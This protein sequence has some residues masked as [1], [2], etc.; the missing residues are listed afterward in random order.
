M[1]SRS[2]NPPFLP[3]SSRPLR[4]F[5]FSTCSSFSSQKDLWD[6]SIP[7]ET[8][9]YAGIQKNESRHRHSSQAVFDFQ[10]HQAVD[11]V[12]HFHTAERAELAASQRHQRLINNEEASR[13]SQAQTQ[14]DEVATLAAP[15]GV[16]AWSIPLDQS[17]RQ[18]AIFIGPVVEAPSKAPGRE[19]GPAAGTYLRVSSAYV[20]MHRPLHKEDYLIAR[21]ANPRTGVVTPGSHSASS[22]VDGKS[23]VPHGRWRQRGD[24][25]ISSDF[26][27]ETPPLKQRKERLS[28]PHQ[29]LRL[30]PKLVA[31]ER[32]SSVGELS[33]PI[34]PLGQNSRSSNGDTF[35]FYRHVR[36]SEMHR[37]VPIRTISP[38]M[39]QKQS[40]GEPG[41]RRKPVGTPPKGKRDGA[42]SDSPAI[43][44]S[45]DTVL[46][47]PKLETD[48]RSSSAPVPAPL[49]NF[50]PCN[51][52]KDLP[53]LPGDTPRS[54]S[55]E[56]RTIA[57]QNPFL[58][59]EEKE[60]AREFPDPTS[61]GSTGRAIAQKDLPC[62]PM[63][64]GPSRLRQASTPMELGTVRDNLVSPKN[65]MSP[66]AES[67]RG[68]R[69]GNPAYPF[70]RLARQTHPPPQTRK[71]NGPLGVRPMPVP[72]YDNPPKQH[73]PTMTRP[74]LVR[75]EGP[76]SMPPTAMRMPNR[77]RDDH[78][79][80]SN[81]TST[82]TSTTISRPGLPRQ[83]M[84]GPRPSMPDPRMTNTGRPRVPK[85]PAPPD[86]PGI[87]MNT[88]MNM[89]SDSIMPML[90]PRVRPRG[91][92]RPTMPVR[93][94]NMHDV[95][96]MMPVHK[97]SNLTSM[98]P[99]PLWGET[100]WER[101]V[102]TRS[103]LD[104]ERSLVPPPLRPRVQSGQEHSTGTDIH[105]EGENT[106]VNSPGLTRK[107]SRCHNGFVDVKRPGLGGVIHTS[108]HQKN[109]ER[110]DEGSKLIHP[111]GSP[112][113]GLPEESDASGNEHQHGENQECHDVCCPDC[114]KEQD[115]H[116]SCLGHPS[117]SSMGSPGKTIWS[118]AHS[119]SSASE[120]EGWDYGKN[121]KGNRP[122]PE[123]HLTEENTSSPRRSKLRPTGRSPIELSAQPRT[124]T[125]PFKK[126]ASSRNELVSKQKSSTPG[127]HKRQRSCSSPVIGS[128]G[129]VRKPNSSQGVRLASGSRLRV[130]T[131]TGLAIS[132]IGLPRNRN[133]SGTSIGTIEVQLPGLGSFGGGAVSDL[134]LVPFEATKMWIKNHPQAMKIGWQALE[135]GWQMSQV[136]TTTAWRLWAL[137]FV[138][139]KTG[140]LK[141][142]VSK[143]ETA[144]GFVI[145]CARSALYL[146]VFAAVGVFL[147]RVLGIVLGLFGIVGWFVKTIFW[148]LGKVLGSGTVR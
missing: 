144:G 123:I 38:Q 129:P 46:R 26:E 126:A 83:L 98:G 47:H 14:T 5:S 87:F 78:D 120:S 50:G 113:P 19:S 110:V 33:A 8:V 11:S 90:L 73:S 96:K 16:D 13:I 63:N 70:T 20:D 66:P 68:P 34:K 106:K 115:V 51:V 80:L 130:P 121:Q 3:R 43:D 127:S 57:T 72:I 45:D 112:L 61:Q 82:L 69:G 107:C 30:P 31:R 94:Q 1:P 122:P 48:L 39:R 138:Y 24:E 64:N 67:P 135:R 137:V 139:S 95:P 65:V 125:T 74:T 76:R 133:T 62:L 4:K 116:G 41:V 91:M 102:S 104:P 42:K 35:A 100:E 81:T 128:A 77:S 140:K 10:K 143:G 84:V 114:C 32:G 111:T 142:K 6:S 27:Q 117:P 145:D 17:R 118:E 18:T 59:G 49:R 9:T 23:P 40:P 36:E 52:D 134:V 53:T 85:R 136:M 88:G 54:P 55:Q 75:T 21:G 132:C 15:Q 25:W 108:G 2:S 99:V 92:S 124:P 89:S 105:K 93:D 147:L 86:T 29:R 7:G 22:S 60:T 97:H 119:P 12:A 71:G 44:E 37:E 131:P 109:G 146:L 141:L 103:P 101:S 58:G 148:V 56:Y 28:P 79:L